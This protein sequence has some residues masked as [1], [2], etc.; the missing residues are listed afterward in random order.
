MV[1]AGY[2]RSHATLAS[3]IQIYMFSSGMRISQ[4]AKHLDRTQSEDVTVPYIFISA[5]KADAMGA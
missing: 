1:F 3:E 2:T 5:F 4:C